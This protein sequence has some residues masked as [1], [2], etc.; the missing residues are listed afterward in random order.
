M[1]REF[2]R[3]ET[4]SVFTNSVFLAPKYITIVVEKVTSREIIAQWTAEQEYL[5]ARQRTVKL[6][7]GL[8]PCLPQPQ[9]QPRRVESIRN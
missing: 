1:H 3:H 4:V 6:S 7:C 9:P 8:D 2:F 5:G